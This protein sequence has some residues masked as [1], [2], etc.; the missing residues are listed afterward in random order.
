MLFIAASLAIGA[1]I[2]AIAAM[3]WVGLS[4]LGLPIQPE[5]SAELK[6]VF[7]PLTPFAVASAGWALH[8]G[9]RVSFETRT[10]GVRPAATPRPSD[11]PVK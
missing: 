6:G 1:V 7:W 3:C 2:S 8:A 10:S 11:G 9:L 5:L 4:H